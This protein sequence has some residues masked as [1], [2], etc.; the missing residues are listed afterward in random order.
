MNKHLYVW[1]NGKP[2]EAII[3][4]YSERDYEGLI[5][6]QRLSFPPPFPEELLWNKEQLGEHV[7]R[8][9]EGALCA[10]VDGNIVGSMTGLIV[11]IG[12]YGHDHSWEAV[13][14]NGYIRNHRPD[15]NTLYVVDICVIPAYRKT[16]IGKW[17]M[18]SMYETVVQMRLERLLGGGRMPGYQAK[19]QEATPQQYVEKVLAGEWTDPVISFLLRCGRVPVGIAKN[20]LEDE[21][22]LNHAVIMEWRNPFRTEAAK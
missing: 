7:G 20:Y 3:R 16:G 17:L 9:R 19:S 11:D 22:S 10:E 4:N 13:T 5:E 12:E 15:G 8:F 21:E 14:D 6:A 1:H 2:V 18:Q